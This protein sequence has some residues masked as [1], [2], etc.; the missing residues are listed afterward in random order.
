MK[1][2]IYCS[3]AAI[4]AMSLASCD[5]D[6]KHPAT[7]TFGE[8]IATLLSPMN[9]SDTATAQMVQYTFENNFSTGRAKLGINGLEYEGVQYRFLGSDIPFT[10]TD[11]FN[12]RIETMSVAAIPDAN[13]GPAATSVTAEI[14]A[15]YNFRP[16][17]LVQPLP[18]KRQYTIS[19]N[20]GNL[21]TARTFDVNGTYFGQTMTHYIYNEQHKEFSTD[22]P[23]YAVAM[24][25]QNG[26]ATVTIYNPVFAQ[27]MPPSM[28]NTMLLLEGLKINYTNDGFRISGT[29]IVPKVREGVSF[30]PN[31]HFTFNEFLLQ[32][33][34]K[35][36]RAAQISFKVAGRYNG[37][38]GVTTDLNRN[39]Q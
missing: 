3:I 4:A 30:T 16:S 6:E 26:T 32:S 1:K 22:K 29:D 13:G 23:V 7:E 28:A 39:N 11:Y 27:E 21:F 36:L 2:L 12:G 15:L 5:N 24:N 10:Y 35:D 38:A 20:V 31:P 9:S 25:L 18:V 14:G 33:S 34:T 37:Q 8:S 17:D 19:Y